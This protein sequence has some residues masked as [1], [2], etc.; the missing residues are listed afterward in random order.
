MLAK[1]ARLVSK[2][3]YIVYMTCSFLKIETIDQINKF[4]KK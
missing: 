2:G 1:A 3:G 4:L